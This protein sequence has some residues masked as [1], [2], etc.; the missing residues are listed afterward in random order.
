MRLI[1]YND[2]KN[3]IEF[4]FYTEDG[5]GIM[6]TYYKEQKELTLNIRDEMPYSEIEEA[7]N[8][9]KKWLASGKLT[10]EL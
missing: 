4:N 7:A 5:E 8:Q 9:V 2:Y 1:N 3:S 10:V 6:F